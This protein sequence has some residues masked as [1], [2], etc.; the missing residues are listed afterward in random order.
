MICKSRNTRDFYMAKP[1]NI[2]KNRHVYAL[3]YVENCSFFQFS[4]GY[5]FFY[6]ILAYS[7]TIL[8]AKERKTVLHSSAG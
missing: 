7:L 4:A 5:C 2:N 8:H 1:E 3:S 6:P